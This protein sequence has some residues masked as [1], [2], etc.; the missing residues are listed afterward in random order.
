[1][2]VHGEHEFTRGEG[3]AVRHGWP[4]SPLERGHDRAPRNRV[5][6]QFHEDGLG[7]EPPR[8]VEQSPVRLSNGENLNNKHLYDGHDLHSHGNIAWVFGLWNR[9]REERD[10]YGKVR[11][12]TA[13]GLER[14]ADP[15]AHVSR[16]ENLTG[17]EVR[18]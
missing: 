17:L 8:V 16:I 14:E 3:L 18:R 2:W 6:P 15:E 9:A 12:M 5:S 7:Q 10:I 1:M 11:T 4:R 13:A